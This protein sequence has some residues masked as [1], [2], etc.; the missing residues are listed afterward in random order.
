MI[1]VLAPVALTA[2]TGAM[3]ALPLAPALREL[4]SRKDAAPIPTQQHDG[5]ITNFAESFR[6][7][8]QPLLPDL[9]DSVANGDVREVIAPD[10]RRAVIVGCAGTHQLSGRLHG[11]RIDA[12]VLCGQRIVLGDGMVFTRDL[13]AADH[14]FGGENNIL[15]AVLGERDVFLAERSRVMRWL[16]AEDSAYIARSCAVHGRLSAGRAVYLWPGCTFER[17]HAPRVAC[18]WG[19]AGFPI[20]RTTVVSDCSR[21]DSAIRRWR[22]SGDFQLQ[23]GED[24]V[25]NIVGDGEIRISKDCRLQ[26]AVKSH[27]NTIISAGAEVDGSVVS[28][29]DV[30]ITGEC[31]VRGPVLA[32]GEIFIGAGAQIGAPNMPTT[33][34]APSIRIAPGALIHGT[35]WAR[36]SGRTEL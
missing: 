21:L 33:V 14:L 16:H 26:G 2:V 34:S 15:R 31:F 8:I 7:Y 18:V 9:R 25:G 19:E 1:T 11:A 23:P 13:Y 3:F 28:I 24:L 32:E 17:V 30:N 29:R 20:A 5:R 22:V 12:L 35:L 36:E 6:H 10:G 27:G 4:R